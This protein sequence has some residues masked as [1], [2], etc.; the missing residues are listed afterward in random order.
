MASNS[1]PKDVEIWAVVRA[2]Q[3]KYSI[4]NCMRKE[5]VNLHLC[6]QDKKPS[7]LELYPDIPIYYYFG[8]N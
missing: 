7:V 5:E 8:R 6:F 2:L 4:C 1:I 3:T